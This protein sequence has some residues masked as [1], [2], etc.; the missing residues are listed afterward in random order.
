MSASTVI[1]VAAG[2]AL[3]A[4]VAVAVL[5]RPRA[6][7]GAGLAHRR[8]ERLHRLAAA[9]SRAADP[10][11]VGGAFLDQALEHLGAHGGSLVLRSA[12]GTALELVAGRELPGAKARLLQRISIEENFSVTVAYRTGA[13][14][15]ARTPDEL[16]ERFPTSASTFGPEARALYALPLWVG[17]EPAGAFNLFFRHEHEVSPEDAEFL[18]TMA[19][20]C[21][22]ALERALLA[23]AESQAR[24]QAE[25]A[26]RYATSL[27]SLGMR[28][29]TSLTPTDVA[30]TVMREATAR[31][32]AAAAAVGLIDDERSEVQLL[33]DD[34]YPERALAFLQRF[35][36]DAP[37][38]AAAAART[39]QPVFV[40]TLAERAQRFPELPNELG[41]GSVAIAALPLIAAGTTFG[42]LVLRYA[43][44][45]AFG[46]D[47]RRFLMTLADDCSQ[48]LDR[49]RLHADAER[50]ATRA[51]LLLE[52]AN[53]LDAASGHA[54]RAAALLE[55]LVPAHGDHASIETFHGDG[56][57]VSIASRSAAGRAGADASALRA[58]AA[59]LIVRVRNSGVAES[60]DLSAGEDAP[61]GAAVAVP[62]AAAARAGEVLLV[63]A[64]HT[65]ATAMRPDAELIAE[66]ARGAAL[67]LENA[68]LYEREHHI[69]HTLQHGLLP[70]ALPQAPGFDFAV[71]YA[72]MGEGNEVGGDFYDVFATRDA[73]TAIVGDVCGKGPEAARLTALCRHTLRAAALFEGAGPTRTLTLLNRAIL[74]Q[75]PDAQFCTVAMADLT[76]LGS[77]ALGVTIASAGHPA[78]VIVRHDGAIEEPGARGTVLGVVAEPRLEE[79]RFDLGPGDALVFVT[80]GVEE[81]RSDAGV[82]YGRARLHAAAQRAAHGTAAALVTAIRDDLDAF[83]GHRELHDDI[84]ILVV[85]CSPAGGTPHP[86]VPS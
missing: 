41:D 18:A 84:V 48:A 23:E 42:V 3:G 78:T 13:P 10:R 63:I 14:A 29:A 9:L 30:E 32:G 76:P 16:R 24:E 64:A 83:R 46:E 73:Y 52:I 75:A 61:R 22:Q 21:G 54:E 49:A 67:A 81:A 8:T 79:A 56:A 5:R 35:G 33:V 17:G 40:G 26:A 28:L 43:D 39:S 74:E 25:E 59:A 62:L 77:G 55:A 80:D 65:E 68:R 1:A 60:A 71:A 7:P 4:A 47:E 6:D 50:R 57:P 15:E 45:R 12:D 82:F 19:Q 2:I 34:D 85:R 36:L 38:P 11:E 66:I 27:Y 20:L 69:A 86:V 72:P 31:H 44:E 58:E 37:F 51:R 70:P 53:S